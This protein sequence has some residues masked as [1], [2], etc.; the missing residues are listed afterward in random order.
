MPLW[1]LRAVR[2]RAKSGR[3]AGLTMRLTIH[4]DYALRTLIYLGLRPGLVVSVAEIAESFAISRNHLVK[5]AQ[6]LRDGGYV[7]TTRG[8]GGGVRL[9]K[10]AASINIGDVVRFMENDMALVTCFSKSGHCR[11]YPACLLR[12]AL[13]EA[14]GAFLAVLD[15]F[16]LA[17]LLGP[18][19]DLLGALGL[20]DAA[21]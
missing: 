20:G 5:V 16:C 19:Q 21:A 12:G 13:Q 14:L 15:R 7:E 2:D 10:A 6:H 3:K 8:N 18:R 4:T 11:I 9:V 17:D 1:K